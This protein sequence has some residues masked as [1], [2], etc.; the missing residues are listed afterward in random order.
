MHA[1]PAHQR[2]PLGGDEGTPNRYLRVS[3]AQHDILVCDRWLEVDGRRYPLVDLRPVH[4]GHSRRAGAKAGWTLAALVIV[5]A[6]L[7]LRLDP[8][9]WWIV[10][11]IAMATAI[12]LAGLA[13]RQLRRINA[14]VTEVDGVVTI[15]IG[16]D[17][18]DHTRN[19]GDPKALLPSRQGG[20]NDR[21][22]AV[23]QHSYWSGANRAARAGDEPTHHRSSMVWTKNRGGLG[24]LLGG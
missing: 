5:V 9:V 20:T 10:A 7:W 21:P 22:T 14:M 1:T 13:L 16:R 24:R 2:P 17:L 15:V 12:V 6:W 3:Y 4:T 18:A 23:N 8:R 11:L 19:R